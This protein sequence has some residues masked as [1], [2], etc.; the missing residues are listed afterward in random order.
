M[1]IVANVA[2]SHNLTVAAAPAE[3]R[4]HTRLRAGQ[5]FFI[6]DEFGNKKKCVKFLKIVK[7]GTIENEE[8]SDSEMDDCRSKRNSQ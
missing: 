7:E 8:E 5:S 6:K 1:S 3:H 2:K 4:R